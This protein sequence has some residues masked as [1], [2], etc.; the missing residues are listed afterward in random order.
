MLSWDGT[1]AT[2]RICRPCWTLSRRPGWTRRRWTTFAPGWAPWRRRLS[3]TRRSR[4]RSRARL[5]R[6]RLSRARLSRTRLSRTRLSRKRSRPA[7]S[8]SASPS[9][10]ATRGR[11]PSAG[12]LARC[13]PP[14]SWRARPGSRATTST[15]GRP[16]ATRRG[17]NTP[18]SS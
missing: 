14:P 12:L 11:G 7:R 1:S 10:T 18:T 17:S 4:K 9:G 16:P 5:S 15:C 3:R 8:S 13:T 6:T 2:P